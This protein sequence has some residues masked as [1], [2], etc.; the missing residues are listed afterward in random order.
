ML[1]VIAVLIVFAESAQQS[2]DCSGFTKQAEFAAFVKEIGDM[3]LNCSLILKSA[4]KLKSENGDYLYSRKSTV[5][6]ISTDD[7]HFKKLL[8]SMPKDE[9]KNGNY[10]YYGCSWRRKFLGTDYYYQEHYEGTVACVFRRNYTIV[11]CAAQ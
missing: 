11:K 10:S 6:A 2:E 7:G 4:E 3:T 5:K 9:I 8:S 1:L